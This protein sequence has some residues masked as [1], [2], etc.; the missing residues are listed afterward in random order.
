MKMLCSVQ[1]SKNRYK[2]PEGYLVCKDCIIARTG[3]Q[4]Y[5]KS[6][7]GRDDGSDE[8]YIDI[9]RKPEQV[10]DEKTMASFEGKPLTIEHPDE[11]VSPQNYKE[12]AVGNVHNIRKGK[13]EGQDVMYADIN[14][15]DARAI[16][17]IETGEMEELSCGYDCDITDGPNPE[18]INIRGNHVALCEQGRAGIARIQDSKT[19]KKPWGIR[20]VDS[21]SRGT[22][23]QEFGKQGKQYKISKIN[24]NVIYAEELNTGRIVLFKKDEENVEWATITKSE[25]RDSKVKDEID[26][27]QYVGKEVDI[28][29]KDGTGCKGVMSVYYGPKT[30][31]RVYD[32]DVHYSYVINPRN[33]KEIKVLKDYNFKDVST[34]GFEHGKS[35]ESKKFLEQ[36]AE[37]VGT[38]AP[39]AEV[40]WL[41]H[42]IIEI[43]K[44]IRQYEDVYKLLRSKGYDIEEGSSPREIWLYAPEEVIKDSKVKDDKISPIAKE[45]DRL[46]DLDYSSHDIYKTIHKNYPDLS[47]S[48]MKEAL[49]RSKRPSLKGAML[50]WLRE[51]GFKDSKVKDDNVNM[52]EEEVREIFKSNPRI[53]K[54]LLFPHKSG[55]DYPVKP[56][57]LAQIKKALSEYYDIKLVDNPKEKDEYKYVEGTQGISDCNGNIYAY[58]LDKNGSYHTFVVA[59]YYDYIDEIRP[60]FEKDNE[61]V[62]DAKGDKPYRP[63]DYSDAFT[64]KELDMFVKSRYGDYNN[65]SKRKTKIFVNKEERDEFVK[66]LPKEAEANMDEFDHVFDDGRYL[67]YWEVY[68]WSDR[69]KDSFAPL[70]IIQLEGNSYLDDNDRPTEDIN[71]AKR[72]ATEDEANSY[73]KVYCSG[74]VQ[75]IEDSVKLKDGFDAQA[76]IPTVKD[77]L[78]KKHINYS[79]IDHAYNSTTIDFEDHKDMKKAAKVLRD[80]YKLEMFDEDYGDSGRYIAIYSKHK[81]PITDSEEWKGYNLLKGKPADDFKQ[82]LRDRGLYFEPSENGKFIHFEVKHADEDVEKEIRAINKHY[83]E[84]G[85]TD[86]Y[87]K[88]F[89]ITAI[90]ELEEK[91]KKAKKNELLQ[92]NQDSYDKQKESMVQTLEK[93]IAEYKEKLNELDRD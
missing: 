32:E 55:K 58:F 14:V 69:F 79:K 60:L 8:E 37:D 29:Y 65:E 15:Y 43:R 38:I 64:N 73:R 63:N 16:N 4:T 2:T 81:N 47:A 82:Y 30:V 70:Y 33:I 75:K 59:D 93:Q 27:E 28:T 10:F 19:G 44:I 49:S 31:Y 80:Y 54:G 41:S 61:N 25:V 52:T 83:T 42:S 7:I 71:K 21:V 77:L 84:V 9:D 87:S 13:Y 3:K 34:H 68:Y 40:I 20:A 35:G 24:G 12:L 39:N 78:D 23:I 76:E 53:G 22:L 11:S 45:I 90:K 72:F 92:S 36:V 66:S 6:E 17:L 50:H 18:Q 67:V 62:E 91:L 74:T 86:A 85:L 57:T 56:R 26:L 5:L 48:E 88:R 46:A 89:Y 1:L 51:L